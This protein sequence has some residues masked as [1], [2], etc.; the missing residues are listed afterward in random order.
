MT[1]NTLFNIIYDLENQL[2]KLE[3]RQ[4]RE[5]I[6]KLLSDDFFE[7]TSSGFVWHYNKNNAI[8]SSVNLV[9]LDWEIKDFSIKVLAADVIL[10]TYKLV[11]NNEEDFQKKYSLRSSIWENTDGNWKMIFHQGTPMFEL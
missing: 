5:K 7:F 4:S 3:T 11:K 6:S 9:S 2:L 8:D 1:E 10:A